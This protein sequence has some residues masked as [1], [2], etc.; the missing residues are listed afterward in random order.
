MTAG[1]R[2]CSDVQKD[3]NILSYPALVSCTLFISAVRLSCSI[4]LAYIRSLLLSAELSESES[5]RS[6]FIVSFG[7]QAMY[8]V[9]TRTWARRRLGFSGNSTQLASPL[10]VRDGDEDVSS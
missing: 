10:Q 2:S 4:I 8:G 6:S 1:S 5:E 7:V 9:A 3:S